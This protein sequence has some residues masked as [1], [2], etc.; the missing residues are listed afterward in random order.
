M[1]D[2]KLLFPS[3]RSVGNCRKDAKRLAQESG[4]PLS[5]AQDRVVAL[6]GGTGTWSQSL[7]ALRLVPP[8]PSVALDGSTMTLA[9]IQAVLNKHPITLF[10]H[11]PSSEAVTQG[12][13]YG[14][15]LAAGQSDLL[16]DLD[17]C[18][19]AIRFLQHL[20]K[21]KTINSKA[22]SS[23][24]LKHQADRFL[25]KL[26]DAP[27]NPYVANGAFICAAEHMGFQMGL[28]R[29]SP[30][31]TFNISSRS[32]AFEWDRLRSR[33]RG[34]MGITNQAADRLELLERQLGVRPTPRPWYLRR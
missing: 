6:N 23:Y 7:I 33:S 19:K 4:V 28:Y 20:D 24:G 15:A 1:D 16:A 10:G 8:R 25:S 34:S 32:P 3:G 30:N 9:D 5:T 18:N 2:E 22:G 29:D 27:S 14:A 26:V 31:P 21:R 11:G 17:E 13:S 12:G